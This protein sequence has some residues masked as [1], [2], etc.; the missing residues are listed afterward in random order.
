MLGFMGFIEVSDQAIG[1]T[2]PFWAAPS[3]ADRQGTLQ[4]EDKFAEPATSL[5][6]RRT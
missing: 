3:A 5:A 2:S 4:G 6:T 1:L